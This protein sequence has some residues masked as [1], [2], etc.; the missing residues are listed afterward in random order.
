ME[1]KTIALALALLR[2]P[3]ARSNYNLSS[4]LAKVRKTQ[5]SR[6]LHLPLSKLSTEVG[7][8][9]TREAGR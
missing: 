6:E 4:I 3:L 1:R 2:P 5:T 8:G 7:T 9:D